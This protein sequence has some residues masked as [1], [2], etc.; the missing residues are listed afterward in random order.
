MKS[1]GIVKF[2]LGRRANCS[3]MDYMGVPIVTTAIY[4]IFFLAAIAVKAITARRMKDEKTAV[5]VWVGANL[6]VITAL[7]IWAIS[8][9]MMGYGS[10]VCIL[11]IA[12]IP[13]AL[14]IAGI[15]LVR[16]FWRAGHR[17]PPVVEDAGPAPDV[18][19]A[20][21]ADVVA[22]EAPAEPPDGEQKQPLPV[23]ANHIV[24]TRQRR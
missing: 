22:A 1:H 18:E 9:G 6:V 5:G 24:R 14:M 20:A 12:G 17:R 2:Q 8:T 4:L 10:A 11:P 16:R 7:T 19:G 3:S 13:L 21:E 23:Q 15:P